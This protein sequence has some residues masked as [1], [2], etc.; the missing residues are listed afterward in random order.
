MHVRFK[1]TDRNIFKLGA[2]LDSWN[3]F[4]PRSRYVCVCVCVCVSPETINNI[5]V[6]LNLYNQLNKFVVLE[7]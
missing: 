4:C 3:I 6:T 1:M 2:R 7:T 5:H